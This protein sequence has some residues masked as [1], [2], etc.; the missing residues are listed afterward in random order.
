MKQRQTDIQFHLFILLMLKNLVF[1]VELK[2]LSTVLHFS[3]SHEHFQK[4]PFVETLQSRRSKKLRI[5]LKYCKIFK[6]SYFR[7]FSSG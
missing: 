1:Y 4:Q 5:I 6:S 7:N 2:S 3:Q